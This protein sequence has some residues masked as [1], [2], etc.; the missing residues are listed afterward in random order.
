MLSCKEKLN[1]KNKVGAAF[2][3]DG[4]VMGKSLV[5]IQFQTEAITVCRVSLA[6]TK[7][8]SE[9]LKSIQTPAPP[10]PRP[11]KQV[12][13]WGLTSSLE[14]RYRQMVTEALLCVKIRIC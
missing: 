9:V 8:K 7:E 3:D 11:L 5:H 14:Q 10:P 6:P 4:F 1:K 13:E 2:T 12:A